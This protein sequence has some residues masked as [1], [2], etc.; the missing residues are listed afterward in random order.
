MPEFNPKPYA[1]EEIDAMAKN[2][3]YAMLKENFTQR[4]ENFDQGMFQLMELENGDAFID[5]CSLAKAAINATGLIQNRTLL[6]GYIEG[7]KWNIRALY[8]E[9]AHGDEEHRKWL[10]DKI[11]SHFRLEEDNG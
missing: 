7:T 5:Y 4:G 1:D 2:A 3:A 6:C 8:D 9:I 10:R 11:N